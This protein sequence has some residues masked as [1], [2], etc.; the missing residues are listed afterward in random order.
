MFVHPAGVGWIK[1]V[2][3]KCI[4]NVG[5]GYQGEGLSPDPA[6]WLVDVNCLSLGAFVFA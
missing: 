3:G 2:G 4:L 6:L 5:V 1:E